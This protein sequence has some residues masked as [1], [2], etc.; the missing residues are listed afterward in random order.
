[1]HF[2]TLLLETNKSVFEIATD[3]GYSNSGNFGNAFKK[4]YGVA[5]SLYRQK[6]GR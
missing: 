4:R 6:G 5:P 1:L 3:I 2:T